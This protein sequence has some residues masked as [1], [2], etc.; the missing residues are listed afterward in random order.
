[1]TNNIN[2][3]MISSLDRVMRLL[4]RRPKN[5]EHIGRGVF[6]LLTTVENNPDISTKELANILGIRQSSLN[7]RLSKLEES[8]LIIRE[9]DK[10]DQRV[11]VIRLLEKGKDHLKLI[12]EDRQV[13]NESISQ[14]LDEDEA[15]QLTELVNKLSDGIEKINSHSEETV[16]E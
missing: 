16:K 11:F 15:K 2:E 10:A 3:N 9:R 1:M 7:E 13:F 6:R 5:H 4:R 8:E 14:I 12:K